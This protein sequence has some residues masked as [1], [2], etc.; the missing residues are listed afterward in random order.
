M[1]K[2]PN[3]G[4][5][6]MDNYRNCKLCNSPLDPNQTKLTIHERG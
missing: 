1:K 5:A 6:N 2:C 3:C 4:K